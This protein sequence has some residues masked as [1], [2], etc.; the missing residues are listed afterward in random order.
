MRKLRI[1]SRKPFWWSRKHACAK[2]IF[3]LVS[4]VRLFFFLL[5]ID[6]YWI[7]NKLNINKFLVLDGF[8]GNHFFF[9]FFN[10]RLFHFNFTFYVVFIFRILLLFFFFPFKHRSFHFI[11]YLLWHLCKIP[12]RLA[13]FHLNEGAWT[14]GI[15]CKWRACKCV[16]KRTLTR[17]IR[18]KKRKK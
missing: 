15:L 16:G 18:K 13:F 10:L 14:F 3:L 2:P 12:K 6:S 5:L 9:F 8:M 17:V 1:Y 11:H 7:K 4:F